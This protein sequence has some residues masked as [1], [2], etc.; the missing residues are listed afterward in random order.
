MIQGLKARRLLEGYRGGESADLARLTATLLAFSS[1]VM[2][3]EEVVESIDINPLLCSSS[4][5]V[6]ADA[7]IILCKE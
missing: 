5:C 2:E 1:L 3:L 7:R 4:R 6:V